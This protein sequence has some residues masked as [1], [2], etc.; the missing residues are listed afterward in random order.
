MVFIASTN[1]FAPT[2]RTTT[3]ASRFTAD[4]SASHVAAA[5]DAQANRGGLHD[6][7]KEL[8]AMDWLVLRDLQAPHP[9]MRPVGEDPEHRI[10]GVSIQLTPRVGSIGAL[11]RVGG[12]RH[13]EGAVDEA[14]VHAESVAVVARGR[15]ASHVLD[16]LLVGGVHTVIVLDLRAEVGDGDAVCAM[17]D[18]FDATRKLHVAR[19]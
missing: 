12:E 2:I 17:E 5:V 8:R 16:D 1:A 13:E 18:L 6:L 14:V 9:K 11:V 3:Y 15:E 7:L 4:Y 10:C 19:R